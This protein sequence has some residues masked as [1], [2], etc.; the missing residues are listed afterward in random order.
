MR[1]KR[2]SVEAAQEEA[3]AAG[4]VAGRYHELREMLVQREPAGLTAVLETRIIEATEVG[5]QRKASEA[6]LAEQA[7]LLEL[8]QLRG[9]PPNTKV[10][11]EAPSM[12]F[13][14]APETEVLLGAA[15]TN[16]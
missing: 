4:E 3:A 14:S 10:T 7:A 2:L 1:H 11:I 6:A 15:R 5:L 13:A 8:N 16:N 9:R 12:G